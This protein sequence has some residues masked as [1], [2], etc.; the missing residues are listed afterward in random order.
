ML[1]QERLRELLNYDPYS[2][3]FTRRV[4]NR[5][6]RV[7][8]EPGS[9]NTKGYI[10]IRIDGTLYVA[11]RLAW[12]YIYG[13]WP[14]DQ[15]D[16]INGDKTDNRMFNL[17]E[18]NNKQNQENVPLQVNNTSGYRGVSYDTGYGRYRAYVCHNRETLCLGFYS[19]AEEA[20][21]VAK[22]ARDN[23]FTHHKTEYSS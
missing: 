1:T 8:K 3:K 6:D 7:G 2:G 22:N 15:L 21:D 10:Q 13:Y 5:K 18:V 11:H 20:A 16:H 23:L 14:A 9:K 17:R 12:L 19:T 4:S